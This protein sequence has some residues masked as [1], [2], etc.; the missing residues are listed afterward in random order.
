[1]SKTLKVIEPFFTLEVGDILQ[2]SEDEKE[3]V[4]E[5]NENVDHANASGLDMRSSFTSRFTISMDYA[6]ELVKEN[7]LE[8]VESKQNFIN[9]F[10][11]IDKLLAE[12]TN[13]LS[14]IDKEFINKPQCLKVEKSTVLN[15][16]VTVLT[17]LKNLKK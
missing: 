10:D 14:N 7:M 2:L 1:M 15:N 16:L 3:Y 12:Y 8:E 6:K 11:E 5:Q 9:I 4:I 13:Q 17:H